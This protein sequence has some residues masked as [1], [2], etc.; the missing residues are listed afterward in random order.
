MHPYQ[1]TG[2]HTRV[3]TSFP[4]EDPPSLYALLFGLSDLPSYS[5]PGGVLCKSPKNQK[6]R[7]RKL[8]LPS[9]GLQ[10]SRSL[11]RD[12]YESQT[13]RNSASLSAARLAT[14]SQSGEM[15]TPKRPMLR[16]R[17]L[18][19]PVLPMNG[20]A[21]KPSSE[22]V[23]AVFGVPRAIAP[24]HHRRNPTHL[25]HFSVT[26]QPFGVSPHFAR[27]GF[28][29]VLRLLGPPPFSPTLPRVPCVHRDGGR[30]GRYFRPLWSLLTRP[31]PRPSGEKEK[32]QGLK[33]GLR[34]SA[35]G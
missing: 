30:Y 21:W 6:D 26:S 24:R 18:G 28:A 29:L 11:V 19:F 13:L 4:E 17:P 22:A 3:I 14:F 7:T 16:G 33:G 25:V 35:V 31:F 9:A 1:V 27:N 12:N 5:S 8:A 20:N 23:K 34:L 10:V 2:A 15:V 32:A